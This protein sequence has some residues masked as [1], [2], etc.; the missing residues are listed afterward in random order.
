M[1]EMAAFAEECEAVQDTLG[2]VTRQAW[3]QPALGRWN[4]AQLTAHVVRGAG[5]IAAYLPQPVEGPAQW[6]RVTYWR[7]VAGLAGDVA[8]RAID[9]ARD[10][11]PASLPQRFA[12]AWR[13]SVAAADGQPPDRIMATVKGP[14]RLD[15]YASTR[16]L[17]MVVH[18]TDICR[19]LGRPPVS[20]PAAARITA[21]V[22]E[23]L[24]GQPKPRNLGR[25]RFIAVATGRAT[26]D[27]ARFP[28]LS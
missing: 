10:I 3:L 28:L 20:A 19:A 26:S 21:D 17:E 2:T 27:D 22:L 13:A 5:R 9:E 12:D 6:D 8:R 18:H 23:G 1:N 4:L 25:A 16:V 24:L 11:D 15:E 14:M 7:D